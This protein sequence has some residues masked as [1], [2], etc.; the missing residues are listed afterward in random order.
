M[1]QTNVETAIAKPTSAYGW[2]EEQWAEHDRRIDE[3][4]KREENSRPRSTPAFVMPEIQEATP[5]EKAAWAAE[6]TAE[7]MEKIG[8]PPIFRKGFVGFDEN[9]SKE[10]IRLKQV[11]TEWAAAF[12]PKCPPAKGLILIGGTGSGKSFLA[13]CIARSIAERTSSGDWMWHKAI[14]WQ[15]LPQLFIR[16]RG[17][18]NQEG[19]H[20]DEE[21]FL[22]KLAETTLLILD[23]LGSERPNE[24]TAERLYLI[25]NRRW[26]D[27]KP[28]IITSNL[29]GKALVARLA[30]PGAA[31]LAERIVS[32]IAG[33][34]DPLGPFPKRDYRLGLKGEKLA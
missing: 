24:W 4:R 21:D 20:D 32:R 11:A 16:I 2:T 12:D 1:E 29:T 31:D 14:L 5:E 9:L 7:V 23:D 27:Q 28:T 22:D 26:E 13:A 17:L 33:M 25:L 6:W 15:N 10:A 19:E 30:V 34:C 8:I 3:A 18:Y